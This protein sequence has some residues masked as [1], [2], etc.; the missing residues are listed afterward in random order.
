MVNAGQPRSA[1]RRAKPGTALKGRG[2]KR[3]RKLPKNKTAALTAA[4]FKSPNRPIAKSP[5]SS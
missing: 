3:R 2:F 4:V 1:V 5:N